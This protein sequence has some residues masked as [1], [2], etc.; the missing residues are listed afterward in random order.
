[1]IVAKSRLNVPST[2]ASIAWRFDASV[3]G[4]LPL[5]G[6]TEQP[7]TVK[8]AAAL[9]AATFS[10]KFR[11]FIIDLHCVSEANPRCVSL[12]AP[13]FDPVR[14]GAL[15]TGRDAPDRTGRH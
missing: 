4:L 13:S 5:P 3:S 12:A 11:L 7:A 10:T 2:L 9:T 8:L 6:V 15:T 14:S 1:L